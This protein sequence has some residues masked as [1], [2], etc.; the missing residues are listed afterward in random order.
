MQEASA[1]RA[2]NA[3]VARRLGVRQVEGASRTEVWDHRRH[4][5]RG[6]KGTIAQAVWKLKVA[7]DHAGMGTISSRD[8]N[9][10][11]GGSKQ[12]LEKLNTV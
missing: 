4:E 12:R 1:T 3:Y 2:G 5:G 11:I 6:G 7:W 10:Q 9:Q 8:I